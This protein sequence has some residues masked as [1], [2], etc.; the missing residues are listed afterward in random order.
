MSATYT[1]SI[2]PQLVKFNAPEGQ[3]EPEGFAFHH[4][5]LHAIVKGYGKYLTKEKV[6]QHTGGDHVDNPLKHIETQKAALIAALEMDEEF[7]KAE[8][9]LKAAVG[10]EDADT[11]A[12]FS[13]YVT[14]FRT[15]IPDADALA[16][17]FTVGKDDLRRASRAQFHLFKFILAATAEEYRDTE[18][19]DGKKTPEHFTYGDIAKA[20]EE[21][22][23]RIK[24]ERTEGEGEKKPKVTYL[25]PSTL[26]VK[27]LKWTLALQK[28]DENMTVENFEMVQAQNDGEWVA[29][30]FAKIA[31]Y[32]GMVPLPELDEPKSNPFG[33]RPKKK[34]Q[35]KGSGSSTPKAGEKGRKAN[36]KKANGEKA[37]GK[38]AGGKKSK[39][40]K[41]R[42]GK[43]GKK[44][45]EAADEAATESPEDAPVEDSA[46]SEDADE[47]ANSEHA[48]EDANSENAAEDAEA[49]PEDGS[50]DGSEAED[51]EDEE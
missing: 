47:D 22:G 32:F 21:A 46:K 39:K 33:V 29:Y 24:I 34:K 17:F 15:I 18:V 14:F 6:V 36:G 16:K 50:E 25:P 9:D 38:K 26:Y 37:D 4:N 20:I 28:M 8:D 49:G 3:D 48:A 12:K 10:A 42:K 51:S 30:R 5:Q 11:D 45:P 31:N 7:T 35:S 41:S 13:A 40:S 27:A 2:N 43:K 19:D 23:V 44:D 1:V